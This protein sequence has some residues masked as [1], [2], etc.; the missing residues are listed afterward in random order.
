[1]DWVRVAGLTGVLVLLL[2]V[3]LA[4]ALGRAWAAEREPETWRSSR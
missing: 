2:A 1:M 3:A 4:Y